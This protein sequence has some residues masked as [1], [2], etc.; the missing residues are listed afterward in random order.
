MMPLISGTNVSILSKSSPTLIPLFF[1]LSNNMI[2]ASYISYPLFSANTLGMTKR[3]SAK[4]YTPSLA[5][6]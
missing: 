6:P 5:L 4:A 3:A 2:I 1:Y